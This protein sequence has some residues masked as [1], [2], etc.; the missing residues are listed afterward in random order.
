MRSQVTWQRK[1]ASNRKTHERQV[2]QEVT[3]KTDY[4]VPPL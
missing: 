3:S 4:K 1:V 2:Q